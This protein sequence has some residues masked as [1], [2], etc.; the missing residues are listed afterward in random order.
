MKIVI[1]GTLTALGVAC[2]PTAHADDAQFL[3]RIS[4]LQGDRG[5][6]ITLAHDY[7]AALA[8]PYGAG[9]M[10]PRYF[11]MQPIRQQYISITGDNYGDWT[12]AMAARD[13]YCP[14]VAGR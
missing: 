8:Q 5:A 10:S 4:G 13:E 12:F 11:A 9:W 7:C 1:A 6:L 14:D 3:Q 2:A